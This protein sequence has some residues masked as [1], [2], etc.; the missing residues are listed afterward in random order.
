MNESVVKDKTADEELIDVLTSISV[1][2]MR[3]ARDLTMLTN[4]RRKK[5]ERK[6]GSRY[7]ERTR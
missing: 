5:G 1:V 6:Y 7:F 3:L 4:Q 2:S